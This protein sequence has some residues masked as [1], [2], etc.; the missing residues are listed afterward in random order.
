LEKNVDKKNLRNTEIRDLAE[1]FDHTDTTKL[2][3]EDTDVIFERPEMAHISVRI[4][5]E[6]LLKIKKNARD[7]GLGYTAYVRMILHQSSSDERDKA[8]NR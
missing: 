6:D 8:N 3:W 5:K 7:L 4:P 2:E 1:Y